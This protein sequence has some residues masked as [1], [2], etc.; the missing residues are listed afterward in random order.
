[1]KNRTV[2]V[3]MLAILILPITYGYA[4]SIQTARATIQ[5]YKPSIL[6]DRFE[7]KEY[8]IESLDAQSVLKAISSEGIIPRDTKVNSFKQQGDTLEIDI[9]DELANKLS[10]LGT[11]GEYYTM[12]SIVNTMLNCY[13]ADYI[14]ITVDGQIIETGHR[15]YDIK[16]TKFE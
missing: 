9:S 13:S 15:R 8:T 3:I 11:T 5:V 6:A 16:L 14:S 10:S 4:A 12:G 2:I 1:M 7:T